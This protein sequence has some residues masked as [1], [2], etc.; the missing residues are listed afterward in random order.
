MVRFSL[1]IQLDKGFKGRFNNYV[2]KT[3]RKKIA[4][5]VPTISATIQEGVQA[6]VHNALTGS[7]AYA[8][9]LGGELQHE[10]GVPEA[11]SRIDAVIDSWVEG[12]EVEAAVGA[13]D[14]LMILTIG[15][16]REDYS[17]VLHLSEASYTYN[18]KNLARD[19]TIPWLAWL[20]LEGDSRIVGDYYYDDVTSGRSRTGTGL[21]RKRSGASWGVPSQFA[22]N[23]S[24]N[25]ATDALNEVEDDILV[26]ATKTIQGVIK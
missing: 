15:V 1:G 18:S 2:Q 13:G 6:I 9:L 16:I 26:L 14:V 17:E 5:A 19:V 11:Q 4:R 10:L 23:A 7:E 21:M 20:L 25:F 3:V 22:G 24:N 8:S 12:I